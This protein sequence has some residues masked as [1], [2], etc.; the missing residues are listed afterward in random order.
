M[1]QKIKWIL[2]LIFGIS[3]IANFSACRKDHA[4]TVE[5]VYINETDSSISFF[6]PRINFNLNPNSSFSEIETT[7]A[8]QNVEIND[9]GVPLNVDVI[10]YNNNLCDTLNGK[11]KSELGPAYI[12]NYTVEKKGDNNF[13]CTFRFTDEAM[14]RAK[15]CK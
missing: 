8:N 1:K 9:V 2:F 15:I 6:P 13:K 7:E 10:F 3:I 11:S 12:E 5:W 14:K 4:L